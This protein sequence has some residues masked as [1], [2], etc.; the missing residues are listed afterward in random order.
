MITEGIY[1]LLTDISE[2]NYLMHICLNLEW[3]NYPMR[4]SEAKEKLSKF[5]EDE[6]SFGYLITIPKSKVELIKGAEM[7]PIHIVK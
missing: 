5:I 1:Y 3:G 4:D 7:R 6:I 2:E